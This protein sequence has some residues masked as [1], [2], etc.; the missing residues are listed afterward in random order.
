LT[1]KEGRKANI[2]KYRKIGSIKI[3]ADKLVFI[4]P[5]MKGAVHSGMVYVLTQQDIDA[6]ISQMQKH[7][8]SFAGFA[9]WSIDFDAMSIKKGILGKSYTHKAWSMTNSISQIK[10][11]NANIKLVQ[12]KKANTGDKNNVKARLKRAG[13]FSI[14]YPNQIGFYTA[15][16]VVSY[17]DEKYKCISGLDLKLCNDK[18]YIPDSV[19]GQLVWHKLDTLKNT[20]SVKKEFKITKNN[21]LVYPARISSYKSGQIVQA[22]G[23]RFRCLAKKE[24][25]CNN[26]FILPGR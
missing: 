26:T 13:K 12:S 18:R 6:V 10:L 15:D 23:G 25:Q 1:T 20:Q 16:T 22:G 2:A 21:T 9:L 5:A 14:K 4:I 11:P 17:H 19:M 7:E 3:P 24:K 8:A